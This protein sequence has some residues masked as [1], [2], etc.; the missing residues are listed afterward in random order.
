M[1][2]K[3]YITIAI[4]LAVVAL[5]VGGWALIKSPAMNFTSQDTFDKVLKTKTLTICY[6]AWPPSVIKDPNSGELSGFMIDAI[7][8]IASDANLK[9]NYIESSWG[10]F[11]ADINAGKCDAGVAG[12]YPLINRATAVS[13][14]QPFYYAGNNGVVKAGDNRFNVISDLNRSDIKIAVIQ[15]EFGHVYAQKNLPKA[16]LVVLPANSD[17]TAPL[18]AVSSGQADVGLIMADIVD[19]YAAK[20]SEVRKLFTTP[21]ATSP[22]A[23]ATRTSDQKLLNFLNN[24][25]NYLESTGEFD[26]LARKYGSTWYSIK[27]NYQLLS[28]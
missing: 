25:I 21:Y 22:I 28:Q 14:T 17:N 11:G 8:S 3:K 16:K 10:G 18:L 19:G 23:W 13:F 4:I 27:N 9:L 1:D 2:Q 7:Q 24:S 6:T 20:H 12:F 26:A 5:I 15:G